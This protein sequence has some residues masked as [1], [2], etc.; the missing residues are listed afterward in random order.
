MTGQPPSVMPPAPATKVTVKCPVCGGENN[1]NPANCERCK[2]QIGNIGALRALQQNG[3]A[4][5]RRVR[6]E[7][8][9]ECQ[10]ALD[11]D[12][13]IC[14][15]A[16]AERGSKVYVVTE[17]RILTFKNVGW[18]NAKLV[19]A[20]SLDFSAI[21]SFS[22]GTLLSE[23]ITSG[24][25]SH[26]VHTNDGDME[27]WFDTSFVWTGENEQS[28]GHKWFFKF[29]EAYQAYMA[30]STVIGAMLMRAKL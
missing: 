7:L 28:E 30:G 23:G 9:R 8:S 27:Y 5:Q 13:F 4:E 19:P 6:N 2:L 10:R 21:T 14:Y 29:Q 20:S 17:R 26:V 25:L 1:P 22:D 11:E 24:R 15:M 16:P 3:L 18:V 12:E